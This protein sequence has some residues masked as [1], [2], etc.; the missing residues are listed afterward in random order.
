MSTPAKRRTTLGLFRD[1]AITVTRMGTRKTELVY[2]LVANRKYKYP[3]GRSRIVYIGMT[4][5]GVHRVANSVAQR[6]E[7]ILSVKGTS[8]FSAHIVHYQPPSRPS[9][10]IW[11]K[12]PVLLLERALIISFQDTFG[13]PPLCNKT[14]QRM[15]ASFGEFERFS[16]Q[17]IETLLEDLS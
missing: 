15:R 7:K 14:G 12:R 16:R 11:K 4:E 3:N 1:P 13:T 17:R 5:S 8:S 9:A 6:A 10:K 2:V